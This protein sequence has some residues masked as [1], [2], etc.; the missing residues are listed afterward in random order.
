MLALALLL[1]LVLLLLQPLVLASRRGEQLSMPRAQDRR[2]P[3]SSAARRRP[4]LPMGDALHAPTPRGAASLRPEAAA[5]H[6]RGS[7]SAGGSGG[8]ATEPAGAM[9]TIDDTVRRATAGPCAARAATVRAQCEAANHRAPAHARSATMANCIAMSMRLCSAA[10]TGTSI[11][12]APQQEKSTSTPAGASGRRD[13]H[14]CKEGIYAVLVE[15]CAAARDAPLDCVESR[16]RV[17][18]AA[19]SR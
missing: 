11:L 5:V 4:Q 10:T 18:C 17:F 15:Q 13:E 7:A 1:L 16:S 9:P 8:A 3:M 19:A 14:G 2:A 12:A 6:L